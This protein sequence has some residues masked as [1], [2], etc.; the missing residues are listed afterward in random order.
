MQTAK[1][2]HLFVFKH[3]RKLVLKKKT[4]LAALAS[5]LNMGNDQQGLIWYFL[6]KF[7]VQLK[8]ASYRKLCLTMDS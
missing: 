7:G 4:V 3:Y 1:L 2:V 5:R 6:T 8:R